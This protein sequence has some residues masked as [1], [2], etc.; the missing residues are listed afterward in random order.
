[1]YFKTYEHT[2][3]QR[4]EIYILIYI[5]SG[6][7][8]RTITSDPGTD[9]LRQESITSNRYKQ[10]RPPL[11]LRKFKHMCENQCKFKIERRQIDVWTSCQ[12]RFMWCCKVECETCRK[13]ITE[14]KCV[15]S[16]TPMPR[17]QH[18]HRRPK[19]RWNQ[20]T[21]LHNNMQKSFSKLKCD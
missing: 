3:T 2:D 7:L 10:N 8:G 5:F 6:I 13:E 18:S 19:N 14:L 12:C 16:A 11:K 20:H 4:L 17:P 15:D 1:M 21:R 9:S